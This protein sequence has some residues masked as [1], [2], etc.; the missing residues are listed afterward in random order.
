MAD[1]S[2]EC[3]NKQAD[4]AAAPQASPIWKFPGSARSPEG[5]YEA[6]TS[7]A[8]VIDLGQ[9]A[10][11]EL[12]G[13]DATRFLQ[14]MISNDVVRL[15][16]G[17]GC[18]AALLTPI[19]KM[20]ADLIVLKDSPDRFRIVCQR[21]LLGRATSALNRFI[22]TDRVQLQETAELTALGVFG[23]ASAAHLSK[24]IA[25]VPA[26]P[27]DHCRAELAGAPSLVFRDTRFGVVGY[28]LWMPIS[29][30]QQCVEHLSE[31]CRVK[32]AG[33]EAVEA[34]RIEAGMPAYGQ[35]YDE[36]N[37]PLEC[38]LND[39]ISLSKG[40][41]T[42]QEVISRVTHLGSVAKKLMGLRLQGNVV[43]RPGEE[44]SWEGQPVG[45]VT[46]A[47][48]SF[49][50]ERVVAL[51]YILKKFLSLQGEVQLSQ[52]GLRATIQTLPLV[53]RQAESLDS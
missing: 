10:I 42:G 39:A 17:Q 1:I 13:P 9:L 7:N 49:K 14:G 21:G 20:I 51:A 50:P 2:R 16:A 19:G 40:C 4:G 23:P 43:P 45:R 35:D 29:C 47:T 38:N 34:L 5:D 28:Q 48:R 53:S 41:Y 44:I 12:Y 6:F 33:P 32:P 37:I 24:W 3:A 8:A 27:F 52:S 26:G 11:F 15:A 25:L 18:L 22:I 31:E 46:S 30:V 36:T